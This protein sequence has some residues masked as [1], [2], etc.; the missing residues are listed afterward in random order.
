MILCIGLNLQ[1]MNLST[2]NRY[3]KSFVLVRYVN[4]SVKVA[5]ESI[6]FFISFDLVERDGDL[7]NFENEFTRYQIAISDAFLSVA[8]YLT[9]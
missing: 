3:Q 8:P 6:K 9:E 7:V 5:S 2:K 4:Y 1:T